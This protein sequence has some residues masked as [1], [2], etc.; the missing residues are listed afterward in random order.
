M[1]KSNKENHLELSRQEKIRMENEIEKLKLSALHDAH[2]LVQVTSSYRKW[3]VSGLNISPI[4]KKIMRM[5]TKLKLAKDW[6][7]RNFLQSRP[8][9]SSKLNKSW[10]KCSN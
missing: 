4:L 3:K 6:S 1:S 5:W 7:A 2:F 9:L 8:C 10:T